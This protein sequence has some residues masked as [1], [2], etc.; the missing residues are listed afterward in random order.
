MNLGFLSPI[1]IASAILICSLACVSLALRSLGWKAKGRLFNAIFI[2]VVWI[3][4]VSST[5]IGFQLLGG[6]VG[7]TPTMSRLVLE[8][9]F[10]LSVGFSGLLS[11]FATTRFLLRKMVSRDVLSVEYLE[12]TTS[13]NATLQKAFFINLAAFFGLLVSIA[14]AVVIDD[15]YYDRFSDSTP[16]TSFG[17]YD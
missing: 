4:V 3:V 14:L 1:F 7:Y 17:V 12:V 2:W 5:Y 16:K 6:P 13:K 15:I 9:V 11:V 10:L 8:F